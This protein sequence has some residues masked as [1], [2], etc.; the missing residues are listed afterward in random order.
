M[1]H[2]LRPPHLKHGA[3]QLPGWQRRAV[4]AA[5]G[6]LTLS[7][8]AWLLV[9]LFAPPDWPAA[10]PAKLWSMRAHGAAVLATLVMLGSLMPVHIRNGWLIRRNRSSG[11]VLT[12]AATALAIT[13]YLL[14]YAPEA[15]AR[16]WAGW[17]HWAVGAAAPLLLM[18]HVWLGHRARRLIHP[19]R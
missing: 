11:A 18:G 3:V 12:L 8:L 13:G 1:P 4:Y 17:L 14:G 10:G 15:L 5:T 7:G 6:V 19:G 16:P 9:A 2:R